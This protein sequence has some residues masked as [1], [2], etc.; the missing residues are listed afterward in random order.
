MRLKDYQ[1]K[2]LETLS[3]YLGL[4]SNNVAKFEKTRTTIAALPEEVRT[5]IPAQLDPTVAAWNEARQLG[6]AASPDDWRA[7]KDGIGRSIPHVC[8]RLPTGGGKTLL[9]AHGL[10]RIAVNYFRQSTGLVLWIVPSEAIYTQ[11]K[12]QLSDRSHAL[13][14][15]LDRMSGGRVKILEKMD[16]FTA[17]D[18]E[19]RLCVLMLMLPSANRENR[20]TLK[21]FS[22]SGRYESFFPQDDPPKRAALLKAVPNL[23]GIDLA[24]SA[25]AGGD[26]GWIKHSLGN[27]LRIVSPIIILDEGHH[28]YGELARSTLSTLNPR[29]ILEMTATPK[30][31]YS[32]ILVNVSGATLKDEQM[33]K[34][35][36]KLEVEANLPWQDTL[37]RAVDKLNVLDIKAKEFRGE[38][39]R[40]IRP[41]LLVRVDLTGREQRDRGGEL[42]HSEDAYEF[43]TQKAGF[44]KDEVRRQ[45]AEL[46]E[47]KDD[48]LL[49]EYSPV[50]AIIT[51]DA[52][53][54]GWDCP[55]AY[56]LAILSSGTAATALT[57]MIGR[58]LRQP[59]A[60]RTGHVALDQ[61]YVFCKDVSVADAVGRIKKGL[62]QEGMGDLANE[63]DI[64]GGGASGRVDVQIR[65]R[66][67]FRG[68][69]IMVP[70]VL[71]REGKKAFRDIG[72]ER[73]I[74]SEIDWDKFIYRRAMDFAFSDYDMAT[75]TIVQLDIESGAKFG[76]GASPTKSEDVAETKLDRPALVRRMLEVV[77]NPWQGMRILDEALE[78]LRVREGVT[79]SK[80]IA[81]KFQLIDD[82]LL[83]L[84]AQVDVAA[85]DI[86]RKKVEAGDIVFK[87]LAAP[88]DSLN[89]EFDEV[90]SVSISEGATPLFRH[91]MGE[92]ERSLYDRVFD[93]EVNGYEKDVALYLDEASAV[94]WWWRIV[95]RNGW[96]VK[97]WRRSN[98]YPDFLVRMESDGDTARM[99]VLETKGKHLAGN[100]DTIFKQ[101]LFKL[102]EDAYAKGKESGEVELFADA[103]DAMRFQI[104]LQEEAWQ[105]ALQP[106]LT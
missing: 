69:R 3:A 44:H 50:R 61:A 26:A 57:Q 96:A 40:Y 2:A 39:N 53:R 82:I 49:S 63:I 4:L 71:H 91:G 86:F 31:E 81:A 84:R 21:V 67:K 65:F 22:D 80:I 45:T 56:V 60:E 29:F 14:Q 9:A 74:L 37:R 36:I 32:N 102:L 95:A 92:L 54:E 12:K 35:P 46:K 77:P 47:L 87:L 23:D 11:T 59:Y 75:R 43:L 28:A 7:M 88:F 104:L 83:D 33:I 30:R 64:G 19:D 18:S 42:I 68:T 5:T 55:F 100:E 52:L 72:Y 16:G 78:A 89:Y 25:H 98:V 105:N 13:R 90:V 85:E 58:V 103:P 99:L 79:D 38:S 10:E 34:L 8:L 93:I 17:H 51:R 106:A 101:R 6:I 62:E 27:A 48:D 41:I 97:G 66:E 20:D 24:E 15:V 1:T 76:L 94:R 70:R 73:D